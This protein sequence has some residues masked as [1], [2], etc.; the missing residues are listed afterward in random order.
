MLKHL[1]KL[2]DLLDSVGISSE[3]DRIDSILVRLGQIQEIGP[4]TD[5]AIEQRIA[6]LATAWVEQDQKSLSQFDI[7]LDNWYS[8][9][10]VL[11]RL[12][13][14]HSN[15]PSLFGDGWS[16]GSDEHGD[17]VLYGPNGVSSDDSNDI[18]DY[19]AIYVIR[20][21]EEKIKE[22]E[23]GD[24]EISPLEPAEPEAMRTLEERMEAPDS[25]SAMQDE[26]G[27]SFEF[28]EGASGLHAD[29]DR[30]S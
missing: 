10:R 24:E 14:F 1:V 21:I 7:Q 18:T 5:R 27:W 28:P 2:A 26:T 16:I 11:N 8:L 17:L 6:D 12:L 29:T 19:V 9:R 30:R 3:A 4:D 15:P 25:M 22:M 20:K 13:N 23:D